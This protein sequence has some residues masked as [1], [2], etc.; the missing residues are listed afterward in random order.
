MSSCVLLSFWLVDCL[1]SDIF[2]RLKFVFKR[3]ANWITVAD[4]PLKDVQIGIF[5]TKT[6]SPT[7]FTLKI[8][9]DPAQVRLV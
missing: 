5:T 4:V 6:K 3:T 1:D 8:V 7:N 2:E 9:L